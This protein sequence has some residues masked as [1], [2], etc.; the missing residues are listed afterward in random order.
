[1]WRR[2]SQYQYAKWLPAGGARADDPGTPSTQRI[3]RAR[4][5]GERQT[6][7]EGFYRLGSLTAPTNR[8]GATLERW[9][10]QAV[11]NPT[12]AAADTLTAAAAAAAVDTEEEENE[13]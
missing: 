3:A 7:A 4:G 9:W 10:S 6:A 2:S 11:N 1:V 13:D 5:S 8:V 12:A